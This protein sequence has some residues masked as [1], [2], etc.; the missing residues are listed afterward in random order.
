MLH[1]VQKAPG[2]LN[3]GNIRVCAVMTKLIDF[4]AVVHP[5]ETF[6]ISSS[7]LEVV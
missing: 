3:R 4:Y 7:H 6:S 1:K 2:S 5:R